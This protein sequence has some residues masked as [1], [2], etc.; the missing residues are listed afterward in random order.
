MYNLKLANPSILDVVLTDA[1][2]KEQR[3]Q[4]ENSSRKSFFVL[5][6][7]DAEGTIF[8]DI[9]DCDGC[10]LRTQQ[11]LDPI[12]L[13]FP[14]RNFFNVNNTLN[15]IDAAID[16]FE[17]ITLTADEYFALEDAI[18]GCKH[19]QNRLEKILQKKQ[20]KENQEQ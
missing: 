9:N 8:I 15:Q 13:L 6:K 4:I 18:E 7:M 17:T 2:Q 3:V 11:Q 19:L 10:P 20:A 1:C 16:A 5:A 14:V 12:P